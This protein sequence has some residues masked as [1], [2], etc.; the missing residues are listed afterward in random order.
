MQTIMNSDNL[1]VV[2]ITECV[3]PILNKKMG[4]MP[5]MSE[6]YCILYSTYYKL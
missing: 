6:N 5:E 3:G 2:V 4:A 1:L